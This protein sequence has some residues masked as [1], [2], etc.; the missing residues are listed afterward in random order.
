M[1]IGYA[2]VSTADQDLALQEAG[3]ERVFTDGMSGARAD[4]PGLS[5]ALDFAR[6]GD[7]IAI[8]RLDRL[9]RSLRDLLGLV[10]VLDER[11]VGLKSLTESLDTTAPGGRLIFQVFGAIAEFERNL[12]R[13]RTT[14][15]LAAAGARGR[16][17]GR[18]RSFTDQ[19]VAAA[20][21]LLAD[22][23]LTVAEVAERL[24]CSPATLYRYLPKGG[25]SSVIESGPTTA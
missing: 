24:G 16:R 23:E 18:P 10:Q 5:E 2:R 8:W 15:A 3:C 6:E 11:G 9:G 14:A 1:L 22:P 12:I 7:V 25:R 20:K 13:E 17:G 19:D 4:R 21:A